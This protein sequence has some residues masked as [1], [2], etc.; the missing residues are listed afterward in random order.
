MSE[1]TAVIV[2]CFYSYSYETRLKYIKRVLNELGYRCV[3]LASDFD[4]RTKK[5]TII[6]AED[7]KL[8]HTK[9]YKKNLS[10]SRMVSHYDFA[11]KASRETMNI[12]P[13]LVYVGCPPNSNAKMYAKYKKKFPEAK[14]VL[15]ISDMWP[16]TFPIPNKYKKLLSPAFSVWASVRNKSLKYYDGILFECDLFRN[17]LLN[18][19]KNVPVSTV[20]MSKV[21]NL[22]F[23]DKISISRKALEDTVNLVYVGSI[24]NIIDIS[25]IVDLSVE[26]NKLKKVV[27]HVIGAGENEDNLTSLCKNNNIQIISHGLVYDDK[28]KLNILSDC[29]FGLNI[30]KD[31]VF[32][33]A[34]MKSLE[35]LYYG[36]PMINTI[37]GDTNQL[38]EKYSCGFIIDRNSIK[39]IAEKISKVSD[40]E[41]S[42]MSENSRKVFLE[43]FSEDS[44]IL[45]IKEFFQKTVHD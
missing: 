12:N 30:M 33:G 29:H 4:H 34:T 3:F 7:V 17:H 25:L 45:Q 36:L 19:Y 16:E 22:G 18:Y 9:T 15:S 23:G 11:K 41:Y 26:L 13:D 27:L 10:V 40:S 2:A 24:N 35:Y 28:E 31:S 37:A 32:V 21:D 38:I 42:V 43:N 8:I 5:E 1:K 39:N 44:V 6:E 14:V 20:Y